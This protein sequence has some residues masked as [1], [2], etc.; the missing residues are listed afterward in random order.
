MVVFIDGTISAVVNQQ[1][2]A[3]L[4]LEVRT[5]VVERNRS[6]IRN[7]GQDKALASRLPAVLEHIKTR[8]LELNARLGKVG[9]IVT[10]GLVA[11]VTFFDKS[12]HTAFVLLGAKVLG[13]TLPLRSNTE[14]ENIAERHAIEIG[15]IALNT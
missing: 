15:S 8:C 4:G 5:V 13:H 10:I 1:D 12:A 14:L 2:I 7:H 6:V 9:A 3:E 11:K